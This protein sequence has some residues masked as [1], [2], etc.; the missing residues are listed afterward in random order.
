MPKPA[1]R[2]FLKRLGLKPSAP[3]PEEWVEVTEGETDSATGSNYAAEVVQL[4]NRADIEAREQTYVR[5]DDGF[6]LGGGPRAQSRI[7]FAVLVHYRDHAR[8]A[9]L[10]QAHEAQPVSDA[11]LARQAEQAD[12]SQIPADERGPDTP[13]G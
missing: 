13:A 10:L 2:G 6:D 3:D 1:K 5:P 7:R 12:D 11:E 4:L 8:A 9:E